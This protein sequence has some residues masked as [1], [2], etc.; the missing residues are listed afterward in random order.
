MKTN[1]QNT[2]SILLRHDKEIEKENVEIAK[3]EKANQK[4]NEEI[5]KNTS[6]GEKLLTEMGAIEE[7]K[8]ANR[9]KLDTQRNLFNSLKR[10]LTKVEDEEAKAK[11]L[12]EDAIKLRNQLDDQCKKIKSRIKDN[13]DKFNGLER[14]FGFVF[15]DDMLGE[16]EN[17]LAIVIQ[18]GQVA[19]ASSQRYS[20]VTN[21]HTQK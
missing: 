8:K 20:R 21:N 11:I 6:L 5:Q 2:E 10:E 12:V 19:A 3:L 15:R 9:E 7:D 18:D 16:E 14:E 1:L 17:K 13:R 4:L